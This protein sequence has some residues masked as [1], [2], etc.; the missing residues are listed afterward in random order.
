M[1]DYSEHRLLTIKITFNYGE[2][3]KTGETAARLMGRDVKVMIATLADG[4]K[5]FQKID[6]YFGHVFMGPEFSSPFSQPRRGTGRATQTSARSASRSIGPQCLRNANQSAA[7][8][9]RVPSYLQQDDLFL[10]MPQIG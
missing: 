4:C 5:H 2:V 3:G 7:S 8:V 1:L 9:V 6:P 10:A